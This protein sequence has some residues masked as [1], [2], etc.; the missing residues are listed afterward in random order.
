VIGAWC[1]PG[2]DSAC[3][4][5]GEY[6]A[7]V[8]ILVIGAGRVGTSVVAALHE[9][10]D[11][12][13]VDLDAETLQAIGN[14]YDVLTIPG[15]GTSRTAL[16]GAG[17]DRADLVIA[18]TDR[19]EV[20]IVAA[21][22][23]RAM[24]SGRIVVR[25]S[26]AEYLE[27]WRAGE[28]PVDQMIAAETEIANAVLRVIGLPGA[29]QTDAFAGGLAEMVEFEVHAD[30]AENVVGRRIADIRIPDESV[31]ASLIRADS[32]RIPGGGDVIEEGD[33][34]VLIASPAASREWALR[35]ARRG[36]E[37]VHEAVVVGGGPT[38]RAIAALLSR[39][40]VRVRLIDQSQ[41]VA[42]RCAEDLPGV[43]VFCADATDTAFLTRENIGRA[44]AIVCCTDRDERDL[45]ISLL[46]KSLGAQTAVAVVGDPDLVPI[47]ERVGV[48]HALNQRLVVA[49]EIVRF[50]HDPRTRGFAML[51]NDRVEVLELTIR[52]ECPLIGRPFRER[53]LEGAIVGA[54]E[55]GGRVIFPRGDDAL[56][57]GDGAIILA[58]AHRVPELERTL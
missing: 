30:A 12:T 50:T 38:G 27:A 31:I 56:Q 55:R 17:I 58:E 7:A 49:E 23:A 54:I 9:A 51:E 19:D 15:N 46:A 25:T 41:V 1:E 16:Q 53:P 28:L 22:Q 37:E 14:R 43:D 42:R 39:Q 2:Q 44:G 21:L 45:L 32:V 3:A 18:A 24:C 26:S 52:A 11:V 13:L 34:I 4:E 6:R 36:V 29:I 47:F 8:R 10:H 48:D 20:N 5:G 35:L 57:A 40:G 33:R